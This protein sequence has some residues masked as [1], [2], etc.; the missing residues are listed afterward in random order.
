[1]ELSIILY[2]GSLEDLLFVLQIAHDVLGNTCISIERA[3]PI[4]KEARKKTCKTSNVSCKTIWWNKCK[5]IRNMWI[6]FHLKLMGLTMKGVKC[7]GERVWQGGKWHLFCFHQS[8]NLEKWTNILNLTSF[9]FSIKPNDGDPEWDNN[10]KIHFIALFGYSYNVGIKHDHHIILQKCLQLEIC[11]F[12]LVI[13]LKVYFPPR[14][15]CSLQSY[16][17]ASHLFLLLS[18]WRSD[19]NKKHGDTECSH[20]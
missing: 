17:S 12:P 7:L 11:D 13:K 5:W 6:V 15:I 16:I 19:G 20:T 2:S 4:F 18:W 1:M 9:R 8:W 14:R 3:W 10:M